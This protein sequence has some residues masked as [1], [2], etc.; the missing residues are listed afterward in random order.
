MNI[1]DY[2]QIWKE[3]K[4]RYSVC[5]ILFDTFMGWIVFANILLL[6][7]ILVYYFRK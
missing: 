2:R 3:I 5:D 4:K 1:K 7:I 6:L